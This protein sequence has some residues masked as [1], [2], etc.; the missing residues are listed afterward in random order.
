MLYVIEFLDS[1]Q[2]DI[3]IFKAIITPK[4][5]PSQWFFLWSIIIAYYNL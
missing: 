1:K 4:K 5:I 2:E 3:F